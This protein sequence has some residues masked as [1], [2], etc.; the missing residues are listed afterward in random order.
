[1]RKKIVINGVHIDSSISMEREILTKLKINSTNDDLP[2][3][4]KIEDY[5][6]KNKITELDV[7]WTFF[8]I[9]LLKWIANSYGQKKENFTLGSESSMHFQALNDILISEEQSKKNEKKEAEI[10][11]SILNSI[12]EIKNFNIIYEM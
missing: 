3:N 7:K 9:S 4:R 1:M 12:E 10:K 8:S 6:T 11:R 5:M 2:F